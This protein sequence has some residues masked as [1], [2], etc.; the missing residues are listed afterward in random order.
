MEY[1]ADLAQA[2]LC[3]KTLNHKENIYAIFSALY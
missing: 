1:W 2:V 3:Y